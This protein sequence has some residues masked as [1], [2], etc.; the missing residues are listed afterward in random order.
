M[1]DPTDRELDEA[2]ARLVA[3][4]GADAPEAPTSEEF[5]VPMH[6]PVSGS[7]DARRLV[8]V[9]VTMLIVIAVAGVVLVARPDDNGTTV[10]PIDSSPVVTV[11]RPDTVPTSRRTAAV[12][13]CV[14]GLIVHFGHAD[15]CCGWR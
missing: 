7:S 6:A 5:G 13:C 1:I 11:H 3:D 8:L 2:I 14:D 9:G 12:D 10:R 15:Q 4:A